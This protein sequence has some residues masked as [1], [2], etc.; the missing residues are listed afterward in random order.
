MNE[1]ETTK[2]TVEGEKAAG[3]RSEEA[4]ER[5]ALKVKQPSVKAGTLFQPEDDSADEGQARGG[6]SAPEEEG[7]K[8]V[9]PPLEGRYPYATHAPPPPDPEAERQNDKARAGASSEREIS[10]GFVLGIALIVLSLVAG[11]FILGLRKKVRRLESRVEH[12]EQVLS[13]AGSATTADGT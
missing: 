7:K 11:I 8:I 5:P 3:R 1:P 10:T 6:E 4:P 13:A 12:L 9:M 2:P